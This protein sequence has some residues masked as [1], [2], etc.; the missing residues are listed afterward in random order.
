ME[1]RPIFASLRKHRIPAILI[2]LEIALAC[3][4]LCNAVF[5][6]SK[7][8]GDIGMANAIDESGLSVVNLDGTD[9]K[10]AASDIP[11]NLAAL[12]GIAGVQAVGVTNSL[13][14]SGNNWGWSF[15]LKSDSLVSDKS[16]TNLSMYFLGAGTDQALGLQLKQGRFFNAGDYA[17]ST[18]GGAA[19]P[20]THVVIVNESVAA[21]LWPGKPALGQVLYS[22]PSY[23]TVIGV[24]GN[25]VRPY[26]N[27][28]S[29]QRSYAAT[30]FPL[31]AESTLSSYVLRSAPQDRARI[32]R[33]AEQK[34]GEIN[35]GAVAK[36]QAYSDIRDKYF[37][38]MRSMAWM[39]VLVCVVMLAVTA[40]GIVGLTSFWVAQRRRQI[41]IRRAVGATRGD[42]LSYFRTENFLLTGMGVVPGM[43]LAF[44]INI[45]L[46]HHYE[47]D[48]MPWYYLP[49]SAIALWLLGQ[50]AVLGPALRA[51]AVPPVVA[52]RSV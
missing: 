51:A 47:M 26:A 24:V 46:M 10:L 50:L 36:G 38:D 5:M 45:Y 43:A 14:L 16:A 23:Y 8:V 21:Q 34:L 39:L 12:R 42:I 33:E 9:P 29:T 3:A 13:P 1:I 19:L 30:F 17:N 37:A 41:G 4:V 48:R 27:I 6:I 7:R 15:G 32:V 35:P 20:D 25:V 2:V 18:M 22:N 40:F 28:R 44:G 49:G 11:R 31:R 52:T